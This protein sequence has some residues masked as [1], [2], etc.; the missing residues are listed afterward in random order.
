MMKTK[1]NFGKFALALIFGLQLA[2]AGLIFSCPLTAFA[3]TE[4]QSLNFVPQ[5]TIPNSEFKGTVPVASYQAATGIMSSDLLA[6]YIKAFY[7]YGLAAAGI[8]AAI[9]LMGGGVLWL[10]SGGDSGKVGQAKELITGSVVG[11]VILVCA[12]VILNTINP[13]LVNLQPIETTI[14]KKISFCCDPKLGNIP[15]DRD[16]KCASG[17]P[18]EGD[19][20]CISTKTGGQTASSFACINKIDYNCCQYDKSDTELYCLALKKGAACPGTYL[21]YA[22]D[23]SRSSWCETGV[24]TKYSK[25]TSSCL[26]KTGICE[27]EDAGTPCWQSNAAGNCYNNLCWT[28]KAAVNEPCGNRDG[29]ICYQVNSCSDNKDGATH[30][31]AV[32]TGSGRACNTGLQ[33]CNTK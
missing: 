27:D 20:V 18:C 10:T 15:M 4:I 19:S 22:Y 32:V 33:C 6:R 1:F 11:V 23:T 12:W 21:S 29:S 31:D 16:G 3:Q 5:V 30:H 24:W 2:G 9:I 13:N 25:P 7:N 28:G 26:D 17:M 8:L 14:V